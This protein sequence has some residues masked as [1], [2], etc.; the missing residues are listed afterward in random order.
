MLS[1]V[2]HGQITRIGNVNL[3]EVEVTRSLLFPGEISDPRTFDIVS[4]AGSIWPGSASR[5]LALH[6]LPEKMVVV[7]VM[8]V[9]VALS[10]KLGALLWRCAERKCQMSSHA[11]S[12]ARAVTFANMASGSQK[13]EHEVLTQEVPAPPL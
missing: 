1:Q 10:C 7:S 11:R 8:L 12:G 5:L 3:P 9:L 13:S 2:Q 6:G 4:D